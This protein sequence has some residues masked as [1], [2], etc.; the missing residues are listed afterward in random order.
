M[1]YSIK[2]FRLQ[3]KSFITM[4]LLI[5]YCSLRSQQYAS[6]DIN[7]RTAA[8]NE[9][10]NTKGEYSYERKQNTENYYPNHRNFNCIIRNLYPCKTNENLSLL[11]AEKKLYLS[12]KIRLKGGQTL[13]VNITLTLPICSAGFFGLPRLAG[14]CLQRTAQN[15]SKNTTSL[16]LSLTATTFFIWTATNALWMMSKPCSRIKVLSYNRT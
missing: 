9:S 3:H 2:Q 11:Y 7:V 6:P 16:D 14:K 10:E 15:Y 8:I 4:I 12:W 13:W 5:N 1:K